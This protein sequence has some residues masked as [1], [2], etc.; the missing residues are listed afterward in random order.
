MTRTSTSSRIKAS[1]R[2]SI[3]SSGKVNSPLAFILASHVTAE[4]VRYF[5]GECVIACG[6]EYYLLTLRIS[7]SNAWPLCADR[8]QMQP[9]QNRSA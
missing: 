5:A 3:A 4:L 7:D 6:I 2:L 9:D 1:Q 8:C